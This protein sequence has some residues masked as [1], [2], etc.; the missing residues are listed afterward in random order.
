MR[1]PANKWENSQYKKEVSQSIEIDPEMTWIIRLIDKD[2]KRAIRN[3]LHMF[4]KIR[5]N[6]SMTRRNME[7]IKKIEIKIKGMKNQCLRINTPDGISSRLS[8]REENSKFEGMAIEYIQNE[9]QK[10]KR[11]I[12]T[13]K[14]S[15]SGT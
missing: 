7:K 3:M 8:N 14:Q 12:R 4:K 10:E 11:E 15:I 5:E 6:M 2:I 1:M 9:R 13:S